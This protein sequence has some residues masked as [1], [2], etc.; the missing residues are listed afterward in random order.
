MVFFAVR[1]VW[2]LLATAFVVPEWWILAPVDFGPHFEN[3]AQLCLG[4]T[5]P[6]RSTSSKTMENSS[7]AML[8]QSKSLLFATSTIVLILKSQ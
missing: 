2:W 5:G 3:G 1:W 4:Q 7:I 6:Y 8:L